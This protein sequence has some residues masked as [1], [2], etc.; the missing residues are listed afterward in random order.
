MK[1]TLKKIIVI[2]FLTF[3]FN[4]C[5]DQKKIDNQEKIK[6]LNA[7]LI[8]LENEY[9]TMELLNKT[10]EPFIKLEKEAIELKTDNNEKA[11]ALKNLGL[12]MMGKAKKYESISNLIEKKQI[13][14]DS[15]AG[16]L[17]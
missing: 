8:K 11:E 15:L 5:V 2:S 7:E 6:V 4:S 17:K 16:L 14:I 1:K 13:E 3:C 10:E 12:R 9:E